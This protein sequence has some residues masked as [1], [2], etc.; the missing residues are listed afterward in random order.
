MSTYSLIDYNA[1][2]LI[3]TK[4]AVTTRFRTP[5]PLLRPNVTVETYRSEEVI[6]LA[7]G[8][9]HVKSML[10]MWMDTGNSTTAIKSV[11]QQ[12]DRITKAYTVVV[13]D[14]ALQDITAYTGMKD[15]SLKSE[16]I[17]AV[18]LGLGDANYLLRVKADSEDD[19]NIIISVMT[20]KADEEVHAIIGRTVIARPAVEGMEDILYYDCDEVKVLTTRTEETPVNE[21]NDF[22]PRL[23]AMASI[24]MTVN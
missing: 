11:I 3:A 16:V 5:L 19:S 7:I 22:I 9:P 13:I 24:P 15:G 14:L 21:W 17:G 12:I 1:V 18:T 20:F 23:S 2:D 8:T 4:D 6:V 10:D